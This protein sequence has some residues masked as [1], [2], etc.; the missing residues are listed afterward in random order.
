[1]DKEGRRRA[2]M[3]VKLDW[4]I[5]NLGRPL[6]EHE[7]REVKTYGT[8]VFSNLPKPLSAFKNQTPYPR[9]DSDYNLVE[10]INLP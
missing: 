5:R 2:M 9:F 6:S 10:W 4:L 1:M 3:S 7:A 8:M